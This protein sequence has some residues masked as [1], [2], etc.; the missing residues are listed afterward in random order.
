MAAI[1][2]LDGGM[3]QELVARSGD[4]PTPLWAT[5]VMLDH[6]GM[7]RDIHADY[8]AA[9]ATVATTNTY[10]IHHDRLERFGLDPMF[11]ALHLR[12]LAEAHEARA[13]F[14]AGRIAGSMGPLAAS[15]RPDLTQPV[16]IAAPKYA[17]IARILG[18]HVDMILCETMASIEMCEGAAAGAQA[19]GKPVWLSISVDDHNGK[20]LRS[21]EP[22]TD[23]A[24]VI[25]AYP[26][27]AVL[28]NC[29]VPEA[30]AD[31]LAGLKTLGL[32]FGAYAN[33]FTHISGNFLKDAPT[34]K[35]LTHRHD[36]TPEKYAAFAMAWVEMGATIVGG[37]CD[38][39]PDHIHHL[40]ACLKAA[41]HQIV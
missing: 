29:S 34:V 35:E 1:T 2:L 5:R 28:A 11:H 39:G 10:A 8:F 22:V 4:E 3:G 33:G 27:A 21:G 19:A 12:A 16:D 20:L 40:A 9:G 31:A 17:E 36:L 38:V 37:C 24:R 13:A 18:A 23:L 6:P 32:P 15:Y 41:G 26:V 14:G 30:M 25:K 7:V